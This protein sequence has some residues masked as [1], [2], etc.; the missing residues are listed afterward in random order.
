[1]HPY[2][3]A[4]CSDLAEEGLHDGWNQVSCHDFDVDWL[5]QLILG[6]AEQEVWAR[7]ELPTV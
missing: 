2:W 6:L 5:D 1:M 3:H 4:V 7:G